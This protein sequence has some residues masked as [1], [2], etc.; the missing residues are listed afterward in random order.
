MTDEF[1]A[2][3][4]KCRDLLAFKLVLVLLR[5]LGSHLRVG[6]GPS[7]VGVAALILFAFFMHAQ[8]TASSRS[9]LSLF[10]AQ[11]LSMKQRAMWPLRLP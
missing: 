10:G 5:T 11:A 2:A 3:T 8:R 6:N 7:H 9:V 4:F 1:P